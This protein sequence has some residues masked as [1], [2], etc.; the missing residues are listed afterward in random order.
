MSLGSRV[1]I[2]TFL[3]SAAVALV[4]LIWASGSILISLREH[5]LHGSN[6]HFQQ[7]NVDLPPLWR[8]D[9]GPHQAKGLHLERA[10]FGTYKT[11]H[12][13]ID[14][15]ADS[16]NTRADDWQRATLLKHSESSKETD[17]EGE[18]VSTVHHIFYCVK[19]DEFDISPVD[20]NCKAG[21]GEWVFA[22]YGSREHLGE[23][24]RILS[25]LK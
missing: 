15:G 16:T 2:R 21:N 10:A 8:T 19:R 12:L 9:S 14:Y 13:I 18:V 1:V 25:S 4:A 22:Y 11:E 20:L 7:F 17:Y 3:I 24:R 23:A 6:V 5:L